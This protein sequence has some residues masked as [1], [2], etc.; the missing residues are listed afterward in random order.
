MRTDSETRSLLRKV[1]RAIFPRFSASTRGRGSGLARHGDLAPAEEAEKT[2][3]LGSIS[4]KPDESRYFM[5]ADDLVP[6]ASF[7]FR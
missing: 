6:S 4:P 7:R 2:F 3:T 1:T 5:G